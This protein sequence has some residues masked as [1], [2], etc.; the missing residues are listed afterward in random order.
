MGLLLIEREGKGKG[1]ERKGGE[2]KERREG[3]EWQKGRGG[4]FAHLPIGCFCRLCYRP[5]SDLDA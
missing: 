5:Q 2:G 4:S 1:R 3:K